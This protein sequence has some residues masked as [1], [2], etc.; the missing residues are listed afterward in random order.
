MA[1]RPNMSTRPSLASRQSSS[2]SKIPRVQNALVASA[3]GELSFKRVPVPKIEPNQVLVKTAAV[4]LNPSDHKLLDQS[5]TIGAISGSDISGTVIQVGEAVDHLKV[6]DRIFGAVFGANPG[7]PANG[8]FASYLAAT[9]DICLR[10]PPGMSFTT[11]SSLGM[12]MMTA[13]L[14]FR[15]LDLSF[16]SPSQTSN[17]SNTGSVSGKPYVLIHGGA[18]AT[19][20]LLTQLLHRAGY[21]PL[22]TCSPTNF[23]LTKSRGAVASFDYTDPDCKDQIRRWTSDTLAHAVDCFGNASTMTL[24]YSAIGD[25]GGKYVALEQYPRR[26][27]IRRRDVKADW[28]L[29]WTLFGKEVKLGGTYRRDA[30]PEDLVFGKEWMSLIQPIVGEVQPHPLEVV[31]RKGI[32]GVLPR[33]AALRRGE[34]RGKKVVVCL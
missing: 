17:D 2:V 29:G 34:V 13:G 24:C 20:T 32:V 31:E 27:T 4:A 30:M 5:T 6:G 19:G 10:V 18:T 1:T 7:N 11:A 9:A 8:A 16:P 28:V 22:V 15:A 12:G 26:L 14:I 21:K 23:A 25:R 3:P 33:L